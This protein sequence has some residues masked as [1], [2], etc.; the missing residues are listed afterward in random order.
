MAPLVSKISKRTLYQLSA[1]VR[2]LEHIESRTELDTHADTCVIGKHCL[3]THEYDRYV[4][5][6]GF[7]PLQGSVKDLK[8]V[9]AALAYD[10]PKTGEVIILRINQAIFIKSMSNN[11]L[12]PMQLRMNEVKVFDC[13]K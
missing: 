10:N 3:I 1:T 13:P 5:V 11:L 8:I 6:S 12:C 9:S 4:S 2:G 7:D